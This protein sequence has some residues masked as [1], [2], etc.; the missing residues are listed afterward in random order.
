M[1][2][3]AGDHGVL[4]RR[5]ERGQAAHD[6][7]AAAREKR[8]KAVAQQSDDGDGV[9]S[10]RTVHAAQ[11]SHDVHEQ[12]AEERLEHVVGQQ[13][14]QRLTRLR[15]CRQRADNV[16]EQR[17]DGGPHGEVVVDEPVAHHVDHA[18]EVSVHGGGVRR[19]QAAQ[20]DDRVAPDDVVV[21]PAVRHDVYERGELVRLG[22]RR[23][24][25]T[26]TVVDIFI[27]V[28][29]VVVAGGFTHAL[30]RHVQALS[31]E[32]RVGLVRRPKRFVSNL[33][34]NQH[35]AR[36]RNVSCLVGSSQGETAAPTR[37]SWVG[38][39]GGP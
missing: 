4:R 33:T 24:R 30:A 9:Q 31:L 39:T 27:G 1:Q 21:V 12:R 8:G 2:H 34:H 5:H 38:S 20:R 13:R 28:F 17:H 16:L 36:T 26:D 32:R 18:R 22:L 3:S 7:L 14:P 37:K 25:H 6:V 23:R 29:P 35:T 11:R 19:P 15:A 10:H